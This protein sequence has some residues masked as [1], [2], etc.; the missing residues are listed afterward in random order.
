MSLKG[1]KYETQEE[2]T[3]RLTNSIVTYDGK[4]V[5]ISRV[6][7][8]EAEDGKEIARVYFYEIPHKN[9]GARE[10]RKFL[11]SRKFDLATP[12]MGYMNH[13]RQAVYV[14]RRPVRQQR[15]GLT[16]D[17]L[18]TVGP[19]GRGVE[20]VNLNN[21]VNA[22]GFADMFANKYPSFDEAGDLLNDGLTSSVAVSRKFAFLLDHD[23]E[24]LYLTHKTVRCGIAFKNDKG[25]KVPPKF[26]FLKEEL[27][28]ARIPIG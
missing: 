4:P 25:I 21:L 9:G 5:Y 2:I 24:A 27:E 10:V 12:R 13:Q 19:D 28:E 23:L 14:S 18:V 8:P 3:F 1:D 16:N 26:H 7:Y 15:Q 17:T 11:S 6:S 20:G 22:Q